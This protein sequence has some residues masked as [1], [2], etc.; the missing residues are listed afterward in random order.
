MDQS[1]C[2]A[3][4]ETARAA[5]G[6]ARD[7]PRVRTTAALAPGAAPELVLRALA[8][9]PPP[10]AARGER[11]RTD[12]ARQRATGRA[13]R[14]TTEPARIV[15]WLVGHDPHLSRLLALSLGAPAASIALR[16]GAFAVIAFG[17]RTP[18]EASGVLLALIDADALKALRER[19]RR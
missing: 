15:R 13:S 19:R 6:G 8:R 2:G 11:A 4:P 9:T 17:G 14:R 16:K 1:A 18:A 12:S 5:L 10:P 7:A 3:P